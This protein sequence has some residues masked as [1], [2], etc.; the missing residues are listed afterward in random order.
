M[1]DILRAELDAAPDMPGRHVMREY[2]QVRLLE[3]LQEVGATAELGF[4]GGT[5]L[6][7]LYRTPRF[8]EHL[9]FA[10]L[11]AG[12]PFDL[13]RALTDV[14][15]VLQREGYDVSMSLKTSTPVHKSMVKF[16]GILH[17]MDLSPLADETMLIKLKVDTN[18][19]PGATVV[20]SRVPRSFGLPVR[21]AH[22]DQASLFAGKLAAVLTCGWVKGRD[23]FDL[24]WYAENAA[25]P[26]PNYV[27]LNAAVAQS[28]WNGPEI[29][30]SNWRGLAWKR[31]E[32]DADWETVRRDVQRFALQP[33]VVEMVSPKAVQ[34]A[35]GV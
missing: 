27:F 35:L 25:W 15:H 9:D 28:G 1:K 31:L 14:R 7:L 30:G 23:V 29:D 8:S 22:H 12:A 4:H 17:E 33:G 26:E 18:P 20:T 2:L 5:A 6:R 24:V 3:G 21:V 13:G 32:R 11:R 16:R 19:P 34:K 10:Q